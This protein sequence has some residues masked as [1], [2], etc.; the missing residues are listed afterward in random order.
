MMFSL[1]NVTKIRFEIIPV[2]NMSDVLENALIGNGK[3]RLVT[4][5]KKITNI[6][7]KDIIPKPPKPTIH[8]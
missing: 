7:P 5:M 3:D 2:R 1:R 6:V 8:S 4:K